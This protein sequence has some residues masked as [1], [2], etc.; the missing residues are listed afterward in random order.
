MQWQMHCSL[1][2][3][4]VKIRLML[5]PPRVGFWPPGCYALAAT[6]LGKPGAWTAIGRLQKHP[7]SR[8]APSD[9]FFLGILR[10]LWPGWKRALILVQPE[11]VI[12][13]HWSGSSCNGR[14]S[15]GIGSAW[16]EGA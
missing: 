8:L 9:K 3:S 2:G 6:A 1:A 10:R 7:Q 5:R 13:W 11:T 12:R 14:A 15:R 16:E 4:I